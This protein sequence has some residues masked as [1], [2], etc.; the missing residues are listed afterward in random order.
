MAE[1]TLATVQTPSGISLVDRDVQSLVQLQTAPYLLLSLYVATQPQEEWNTFR[2][3]GHSLL[4]EARIA[5][6][7]QWP[8]LPHEVREAARED[9][10]RCREFLDAFIPRGG[11]MGLAIFS[12]AG[13]NWWRHYPL[14]RSVTS[15]FEW[16]YDPLILPAVRLVDD[17][18]RTGIVLISGTEGRIFGSRL[19]EIEE[20][21][22]VRDEWPRRLRGRGW[23]GLMERRV[24]RFVGEH[25]RRH[26]KHVAANMREIFRQ[27]P[28][29]QILVGGDSKLFE[30]FRHC[31]PNELRALWVRDLDLPADAPF[32]QLR[33]AVLNVEWELRQ[34]YERKL[35]DT[36]YDEWRAD[37]YAVV[38]VEGTLRLLYFGEVE[39]LVL[40]ADVQRK[41]YRC[42]YCG[43]LWTA[44]GQCVFCGHTMSEEVLD[45]EDELVEETLVHAGRV[46]VVSKHEPFAQ[47][48]GV[49]AFLRFRLK[50]SASEL[51]Q[52]A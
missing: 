10:K 29:S 11:C 27:W 37:G 52:S 44:P 19:G 22:A 12:C 20:L 32:E 36:L 33:D 16:N 43:G 14:P 45:L 5:L 35:L 15:R 4:H 30:D 17:Y 50:P 49:G 28:V 34:A 24:E 47:D 25:V 42:G 6:E 7:E 3:R 8:R 1:T 51:S 39:T 46:E 31:L 2:S 40:D 26:L 18:P 48:G 38:G 21:H 23:C 13:R 9:L 41:G